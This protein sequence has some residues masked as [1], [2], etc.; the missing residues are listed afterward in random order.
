[1]RTSILIILLVSATLCCGAQ[2]GVDISNLSLS[3]NLEQPAVQGKAV[4]PVVAH[5]EGIRASL[6]KHFPAVEL[7]REGQ[8]VVVDIPA[9]LLFAPNESTLLEAGKPY[10]RPFVNM[11]KYPTMYKLLAV[12]HSDDTGD[13]QYAD[14]LT[15]ERAVAVCEFLSQESGQDGANAVAYG[16]GKDDPVKP[17]N[18]IANRAANRRLELYIVPQWQLIDQAKSGKLK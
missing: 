15:S 6:A 18:S 1:M 17:N 5:M 2:K 13:D 14:T 3:E 11:L 7:L 9:S 10:L 4:K 8:V 16:V 12:M